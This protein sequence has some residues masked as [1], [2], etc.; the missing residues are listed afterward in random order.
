ME[1]ASLKKQTITL[2]PQTLA[3]LKKARETLEKLIPEEKNAS[4]DKNLT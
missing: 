4:D 2:P 3:A 1:E